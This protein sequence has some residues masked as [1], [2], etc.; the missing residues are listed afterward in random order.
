MIVLSLALLPSLALGQAGPV[1]G[2]AVTSKEWKVTRSPERVEEFTGDVRYRAGADDLRADWALYKHEPDLWQARG[3]VR[4]AHALS[5]GDVVKASGERAA[6]DRKT[7][8]GR[9]TSDSGVDFTRVPVDGEPD[10][11]HAGRAE[12]LGQEEVTLDE[13]MHVWGPRLEAWSDR[14]VYSRGG[15]RLD[16]SGG[17]PVLV[18]RAAWEG[19]DED[20]AW[21]GAVKADAIAAFERERAV[22]A[23]GHAAGWIEFAKKRTEG[24]SR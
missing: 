5:S 3:R 23:D 4:L 21:R 22:S 24:R 9:L 17:R 2:A 13:G 11:G 16:L 15:S 14:G 20:R 8:R 10:L 12:W 19:E 7:G 1:A 6:W 18:K